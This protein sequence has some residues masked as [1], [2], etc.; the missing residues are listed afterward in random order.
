LTPHLLTDAETLQNHLSLLRSLLRPTFPLNFP[1][2]FGVPPT[3]ITIDHP[4]LSRDCSVLFSRLRLS[5]PLPKGLHTFDHLYLVSDFSRIRRFE[6]VLC[7][8]PP[9]YDATSFRQVFLSGNPPW[10]IFFAPIHLTYQYFPTNPSADVRSPPRSSTF[11]TFF[12]F[13]QRCID[14]S[15]LYCTPYSSAS[16]QPRVSSRFFFLFI[17]RASSDPELSLFLP[18]FLVTRRRVP[19]LRF[20]QYKGLFSPSPPPVELPPIDILAWFRESLFK[21]TN[22]FR[23]VPPKFSLLPFY[24]G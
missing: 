17:L 14:F 7:R 12:R 23:Y 3:Q 2:F 24:F 21:K 11:R 20:P 5:F 6:V 16:S 13:G 9:L 19:S 22:S 8:Q 1:T 10:A 4:P 15:F 18:P